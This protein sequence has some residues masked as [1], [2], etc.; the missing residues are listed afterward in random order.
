MTDIRD[1]VLTFMTTMKQPV[2]AHPAIPADEELIRMRLRL[3]AE[4]FW[5][6]M[7]AAF[8]EDSTFRALTEDIIRRKHLTIS[9]PELADACADLD[10]V[11]E[12]LR[13]TF[14]INGRPIAKAVHT[15]NMK[16]LEG[17]VREDGKR[18]KPPDWTPPDIVGELTAQGWKGP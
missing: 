10:Y 15:A 6:L 14:G 13:L 5:E 4:E 12:G 3:V 1:Q 7:T 18:L 17:P 8:G 9:L 2:Q 11:I 16:K